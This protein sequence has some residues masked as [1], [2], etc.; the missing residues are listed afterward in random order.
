MDL[1]AKERQGRGLDAL[2]AT[3]RPYVEH[4][5][6]TAI[7][8]ADWT[9][10]YEAKETDRRGRPFKLN[11]ADP[12]LLLQMIRYERAAFDDI[13]ATQRAWLEELI[14]AANRAAHTT[15]ISHRQAD[16]ALD[17]MLLLAEAL[18]LDDCISALTQ[19]RLANQ[20]RSDELGTDQPNPDQPEHQ[21]SQSE[22]T[23]EPGPAAEQTRRAAGFE[24]D[25]PRGTGAL[26]AV[27]E[28]ARISVFYDEAVNFALAFNNVSP[29]RSVE[30]VNPTEHEVQLDRLQISIEP[31][32]A[33]GDAA[34]GVPLTLGR[35]SVAPEQTHIVQGS[36][37]AMRLDP[38]VFL[39]LDEAVATTVQ[40]VVTADNADFTTDGTIRLLTAEEWWAAQIPESVAA[41]VRPNDPALRDLLKEASR[42]LGERTESSAL[43]GYQAGPGRVQEIAEAIYDALAARQ[44]SY[45]EPP[46]SFEGTGQR[47]RSHAQVLQDGMGTCLDLACTYAAALEQAGIHPVL[48]VFDSHALTGYL[49]EEDQLPSVVIG[50]RPT[51]TT[52]VDS[53][54]FDAIETTTVCQP[55]VSFASSRQRAAHWWSGG[56]DKLRLLLDV[57]AAHHHVRPLPTVKMDGDTR[58]VD[59][60]RDADWS[61]SARTPARTEPRTQGEPAA[62]ETPP[63]VQRWERSLLDMSYANPLLRR[64]NASSIEM[65]IPDGALGLLEDKIADGSSLRLVA[66]NEIEQIHQAQ[67]ARTAADIEPETIRSILQ[68]EDR[69]FVA[70]PERDYQ[71]RLKSLARRSK[72][73]VE[74]TGSDHLYV[75]FG[76]LEW[77]DGARRGAAPLFLAPIKLIGGRGVVPFSVEIDESRERVPNYCLIEKLKVSYG[78]DIPELEFPEEDESG[79]DITKAL[80]GI[81]TAILRARNTVGLQV[82]ENAHLALL[83]FSTLEMW[84]DLRKN[85]QHFVAR[86]AVRHLVESP[87]S[88]FADGIDVPEP[89]P[90]DEARS[91]L[92][93][94]ADG[95]QI[96]AVRSAAA[97]KTFILEGPPGTGKSQTI[98]N[99]IAHSMALG[100]K[101]LFVAEKAAALEVVRRRLDEIGLGVFRLDVH[102]RTQSVSAVRDQLRAA[103]EE[104]AE[105]EPGWESLQSSYATLT[106]SLARYPTQLHQPGPVGLSAWDARQLILEQA[107]L[108]ADEATAIEVPQS[109]V[110]GGVDLTDLYTTAQSLSSALLDLGARPAES[111]WRVSGGVDP[112]QL[113]RER[114]AG[115]VA[116]LATAE[117]DLGDGPARELSDQLLDRAHFDVLADWFDTVDR[118]SAWPTGQ[119]AKLVDAQW[120]DAVAR[121]RSAIAR[122]RTEQDRQLGPFVPAALE[123]DLDRI[124]SRSQEI[125]RRVFGKK[126][127]RA[128]IIAE[129]APVLRGELQHTHLTA[130][131]RNLMTVRAAVDRLR[132]EVAALPMINPRPGWTVFNDQDIAW[133]EA[134]I[135]GLEVAGRLRR[136]FAA[137]PE[138]AG[139]GLQ[140]LDSST[141]ALLQAGAGAA[142]HAGDALR[143]YGLAWEQFCGA[144]GANPATIAGWLDGRSRG[145]AV[146]TALPHWQQDTGDR[147]C[148]GLQRWIRFRSHLAEFKRHGIDDLVRR[149]LVG[150]LAATD[151]ESQLRIGVAKAVLDE[152]LTTS[153]LVGFDEAERARRTEQFGSR[154]ADA[155]ARMPNELRSRVIR[156]RS[157]DPNARVGEVSQLRSELR[158]RR[159]GRSVRRLLHDFDSLIIEI[160]PCLLMSPQ[161][162]AR[163]LPPTADFDIVVFDEASQIR[164]PQSIGALGRG[165]AAVIVGDSKQM[166]PTSMFAAAGDDTEEDGPEGS[167]LVPADL[168][169]ILSE[170][171]ESQLPR[172][173]LSW[174][175]R[176][177]DES[178]IAF[179]NLRYYDGRLATFP[180]P[181]NSDGNTAIELR[182]VHGVWEGGNTRAARVNREEASRVVEEIRKLSH[183]SG[184]GI[185]VVTFNSQQRDLILDLLES[186]EDPQI[187]EQLHRETEPLF[188][189]NLEN[190]QGDER[191]VILFSLA[192]SED[193]KG[194]IPLNWGPLTRTGGERR[195]NV[196]ITRAKER[197]VLFASFDPRRLDLGNSSSQGLRDLKDYLLQAAGK[198]VT[199]VA[200]KRDTRDKHLE[201]VAATLRAAG[202]EVRENVG[203]SDFVVDLAVG[204][205]AS[206]TWVAVLLDGPGW[207]DRSSVGDRETLP[208]AVLTD[209]GWPHVERVWLPTWLRDRQSVVASVKAAV[210]SAALSDSRNAPSDDSPTTE[211]DQA[212]T[213]EPRMAL[214][215]GPDSPSADRVEEFPDAA[216]RERQP[217]FPGIKHADPTTRSSDGPSGQS[218][219][220]AHSRLPVYKPA[221]QQ[222]TYEI[223]TLDAG[224]AQSAAAI[225]QE[226]AGIIDE[227][228]PILGGRLVQILAAR[229]DVARVRQ[230]RREQL[231][232]YIRDHSPQTA[233]NGDIVVW[234]KNMEPSAYREFR[235]PESGSKRD[236]Q[237]IPYQELRNAM[238]HLTRSAHGADVET[239]LRETARLFG[240]TRLASQVW[241]RL[242][243]VL[244]AACQEG[245]LLVQEDEVRVAG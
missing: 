15:D 170:A 154:G 91:Y 236:I 43:Q 134:T 143:S 113:D 108:G 76:T 27:A 200:D 4:R 139:P 177:R 216:S 233:A 102:G 106:E 62:R 95:S 179:S 132:R 10:I 111:A 149:T 19:L 168:E 119:S 97:G 145:V 8:G 64:K 123:L 214:M 67:G 116:E 121:C 48:A 99:L 53:D 80:G 39:A 88:V 198:S 32:V 208:P 203:L 138:G 46:A 34:L 73:A 182:E 33:A 52:I 65:H 197:V 40:L 5:M 93:I 147:S 75:T 160:T 3:L 159:G 35:L 60:I 13:N 164:V 74:E 6:S 213:V 162:V 223:A 229:F 167:A 11:L 125:D 131:L 205:P 49:T 180:A 238:V 85:W 57:R 244:S 196:A 231:L 115:C 184:A 171:V 100:Q 42:L 84:H 207:A 45:I 240:I 185:G 55:G 54:F 58:V 2:A 150:D 66:H 86:P 50:D 30:I 142:T 166:P 51:A 234:P 26:T 59:V 227:E 192:F 155:R 218:R 69:L 124:L 37:L 90:Q 187:V 83:Q 24:V 161:S 94:P 173:L 146:Q 17:T 79:I 222:A 174:H 117:R 104:P 215:A 71:R 47:I 239:V 77:E 190:V 206:D 191:D 28:G 242:E 136:T 87:G 204:E 210:G 107:E 122:F 14:Q 96:D 29:I 31:P 172:K 18:Q 133:F 195:L 16:R 41:F 44:I 152:R 157:F 211:N 188:V 140:R 176:S 135:T 237:T 25:T 130:A 82:E 169:S 202:L 70:V 228:A 98:T 114:I 181:P 61:P 12:R 220:D 137:L 199:T 128:E 110:L 221:E 9:A 89:T 183:Q 118:G 20:S 68:Q 1:T 175:Y 158:R 72:T 126:K 201:E 56:L 63:R 109:A 178:L 225:H 105:S 235:V 224:T 189:K 194:R 144:V 112:E 232:S 78:L 21:Q 156:A 165:K 193:E 141:E 36:E 163:F 92:P 127:R 245:R 22:A 129:L 241:P 209:M 212:A 103:L 151:I 101:V 186:D 226:I 23:S 7:G 38:A 243:G 153:G 217:A 81:R 120:T 219:N 230:A 148:I